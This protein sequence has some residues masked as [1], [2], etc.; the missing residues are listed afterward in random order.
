MK[1]DQDSTRRRDPSTGPRGRRPYGGPP[2]SPPALVTPPGAPQAEACGGAGDPFVYGSRVSLD[3]RPTRS[4][5]LPPPL[6]PLRLHRPWPSARISRDR[7]LRPAL[8][9]AFLAAA[10]V[11]LWSSGWSPVSGPSPVEVAAAADPSPVAGHDLAVPPAQTD[12]PATAHAPVAAPQAITPAR[13]V[14]SLKAAPPHAIERPRNRTV[15]GAQG[16]RHH[17]EPGAPQT[18]RRPSPQSAGPKAPET[19]QTPP[20]APRDKRGNRRNTATLAAPHTPRT[21]PIPDTSVLPD[22]P[23]TQAGTSPCRRFRREDWRHDYCVRVWDDYRKRHGL[24]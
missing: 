21:A 10:G 11:G 13:T 5:A 3:I 15:L 4:P 19:S 6:V 1:N 7:L 14:R 16:R 22:S 24:P 17:H 8:T 12:P 9:C 20:Q 2:G 23:D 18:V